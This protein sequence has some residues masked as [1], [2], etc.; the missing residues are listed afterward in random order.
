[1]ALTS[2]KDVQGD[3]ELVPLGPGGA[4]EDGYTLPVSSAH[5]ATSGK[6]QPIAHAGNVLLDLQLGAGDTTVIRLTLSS[7]HRY[8][9]G[10]K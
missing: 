2:P 7:P 10:V 8:R 3:L 4:A 9:L 6:A 1:L 5:V